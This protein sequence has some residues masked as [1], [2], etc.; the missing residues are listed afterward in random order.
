MSPEEAKAIVPNGWRM[1]KQGEDMPQGLIMRMHKHLDDEWSRYEWKM[2]GSQ[3]G[4]DLSNYYAVYANDHR[5]E[6]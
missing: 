4:S 2:R 3:Y 6:W 5:T 1:L